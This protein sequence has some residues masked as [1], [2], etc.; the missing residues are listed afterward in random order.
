MKLL[1]TMLMVFFNEK[2][3]MADK[4]ELWSRVYEGKHVQRR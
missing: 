3:I 1:L 2:S 4:I